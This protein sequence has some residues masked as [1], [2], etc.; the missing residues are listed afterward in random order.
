MAEASRHIQYKIFL[1]RSAS[2]WG[3]EMNLMKGVVAW[4]EAARRERRTRAGDALMTVP[5]VVMV[6][7]QWLQP[8]RPRQLSRHQTGSPHYT[9]PG[10]SSLSS[11]DRSGTAAESRLAA[12]NILMKLNKYFDISCFCQPWTLCGVAFPN[13]SRELSVFTMV[14]RRYVVVVVVVLRM[15]EIINTAK[16]PPGGAEIENY[17]IG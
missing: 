10:L 2:N 9:R 15:T 3:P 6:G 11:S 17:V 5:G 7:L 16:Q 13:P 4:Q 12:S 14:G 1:P 8:A